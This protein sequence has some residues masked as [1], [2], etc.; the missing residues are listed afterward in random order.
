MHHCITE[1]L[2][3]VS[4]VDGSHEEGDNR[5]RDGWILTCIGEAAKE[6]EGLNIHRD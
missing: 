1:P 2:F 3:G 6:F 5:G 4:F